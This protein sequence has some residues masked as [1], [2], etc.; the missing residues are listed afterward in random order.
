MGSMYGLDFEFISVGNVFR[1]EDSRA[2]L[3]KINPV[4]HLPALVLDDGSVMTES[5]AITLSLA[6]RTGSDDP[7]D[8][9]AGLV[10]HP[11]PAP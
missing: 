2:A 3:T 8:P 10:R 4:G 9:G 7:L 5:A 11:Y 1:S 6:E